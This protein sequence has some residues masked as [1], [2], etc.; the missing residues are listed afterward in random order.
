MNKFVWVMF[1]AGMVIGQGCRKSGYLDAKPSTQLFVPTT[2]D[3]FQAML[4]KDN[5]LNETPVLAELSS[6][7]YYLTNTL[8]QG[9]TAKEHNAYIWAPDT[10]QG[11]GSV[12]DW[13]EPYQQVFYANI[14]L[15]GIGNI[16]VTAANEQQWKALKGA[17]YF[18]RGYAFYNL[19]QVFAPVYDSAT[20]AT[21]LGI[22]LRLTP[23]VDAPS[24][25]A[26]VKETYEQ[27]I[28]DITNANALLPAAI[29]AANRNRPCQP[30]AMA[31]LARVYLSMRAY[32]KAWAS[33]DS[34]LH[35]YNTLIDFNSAPST[36]FP[37][38]KLNN[39]TLYQSRMYY[40]TGVLKTISVTGC[41]VDSTLYRSYDTNDLRKTLFYMINSVSGLP[42]AKGNFSGSTYSFSGL[43]VDEVYLV[44]AEC[45]ARAGNTTSAMSDLNTLLQTRWKKDSFAVFTAAT[46]A[47][48]L[49][50]VLA[51]RRKELA[52]RGLRWSDIRRLNKEN[53]NIILN[54]TINGQSY[55]LMPGD[56]R[57]VFPIPPDVIT[58]SG[59][60][61]NPR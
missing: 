9:L 59:I 21:D 58:L 29:V 8:W 25:R 12:V 46:P 61:Q 14:V 57:Y 15:D 55:Q 38:G 47:D 43:A 60:Q 7:N 3:D 41:I 6:D 37:F 19:A 20:A 53:Y 35:Q 16:P 33:A 34:C 26:S 24:V 44:R 45:Y 39:E 54:R 40:L 32:T 56:L 36:G 30:A 49:K 23:G 13:N 48:A 1:L 42:N 18:M 27:V 10:Y 50:L 22:P 5:P 4:D 2:L 17:A 11:Q 31:L 28:S 51:E 52:F